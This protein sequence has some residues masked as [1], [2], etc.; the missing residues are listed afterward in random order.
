[1]L[2]API[3][4]T[5][6]IL[7]Q[8]QPDT[9]T[10]NVVNR[11]SKSFTGQFSAA[12]YDLN[13]NFAQLI[14]KRTVTNPLKT[15]FHYT[16]P[17]TFIASSITVQPGTYILL[18]VDSIT[19]GYWRLTGCGKY[20]NPIV[21]SVQ[22][23]MQLP[24]KYEQNDSISKSYLLPIT[25]TNNN[26]YT[27]TAGSNIHIGTDNDFYKIKLPKGYSYTISPVLNNQS[28]SRTDSIYSVN[29]IF[30]MSYDSIN[31]TGTYQDTLQQPITAKSGQTIYFRVAPYFQ[32][33]KGTYLFEINLVRTATTPITFG[34]LTAVEKGKDI[35]LNWNTTTELN[36]S[37]FIIQ[38]STDG[39]SFT[40]IGTVKAIGSGANSY[41]FADNKPNNGINYYRLQSVDKDG[42][43]AY[44]KVVSVQL[45]VNSNQFSVFPNPSKDKVTIQGN[46]IAF[47]QVVDNLGRV[48]KTQ[49]LKDATNP[50]LSVSALPVGVYHL[51]IQ[52]ADGKVSGVGF[53]KE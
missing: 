7:T 21:V 25:F 2:Y 11:A 10:L 32:G 20:T 38:R 43:F 30:S 3:K 27:N 47:V 37:H 31:W 48:V 22:A 15:G 24:D 16:N 8:G 35:S 50:T 41:T 40:D 17:V 5:P 49:N 34:E 51:R 44:S 33:Q 18:V 12:L 39:S 4:T 36:T 1:V 46:H 45:T 26:G 52:T 42:S 14:G 23:P 53:V 19:N 6:T 28:Y 13:G 29:A 9:V